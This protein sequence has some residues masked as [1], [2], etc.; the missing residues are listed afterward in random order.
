M[1]DLETRLASVLKVSRILASIS[2][3]PIWLSLYIPE[4]S[5]T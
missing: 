1:R 2:R 3:C 4:A 5:R